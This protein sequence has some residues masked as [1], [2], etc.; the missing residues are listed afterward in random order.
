MRILLLLALIGAWFKELPAQYVLIGQAAYMNNDCIQLTPDVAYS[1][2]IAYY[3]TRLNLRHFFQVEFDIYLGDKEEGADG[4]T[5][6]IHNDRRGFEAFGT[7][8]ECMGYG[9]W[10]KY[11]RA[12]AFIAPSI[13]IE[14]DTYPNWQQNDPLH[15][16]VAYLEDGTNYHEAWWPLHETHF[17][18]EDD[19][20]HSFVFRWEP[21]SQ[22]ITVWL[23]GQMVYRGRRDLINEVFK[24]E[25]YVI[26]GF[27]A[28]TGRAS[29]LQYF[30]LRNMAM[31]N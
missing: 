25:P 16:H 9:R 21:D 12:G 23:D 11:Y 14:F 17:N 29:N 27:T 13:A 1:E 19:R 22:Q 26:W 4:I 31:K 30:C 8:G 2:G 28:S 20:L 6:V 7:W 15:D 10:S 3:R 18:L 5:F 24:G